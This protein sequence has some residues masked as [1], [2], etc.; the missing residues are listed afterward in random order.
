ME[1]RLKTVPREQVLAGEDI[2][3]ILPQRPPMLMVDSFYGMEGAKAYCGLTVEQDNVF[4]LGGK[5]IE[6]GIL[7]HAAQSVAAMSGYR[8]SLQD[9]PPELGFIGEVKS[10]RVSFLPKAGDV[11]MTEV[12]EKVSVLGTILAGVRVY[13]SGET[14][15]EGEL[16]FALVG[17]EG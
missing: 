1:G 4:C 10:F 3:R 16:K 8:N 9:L 15:A 2:F 7:E 12:E 17:N 13:C 6:I 11:L 14:V 5:F